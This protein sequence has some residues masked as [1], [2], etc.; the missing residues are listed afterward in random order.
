MGLAR[1]RNVA[2]LPARCDAELDKDLPQVPFDRVRAQ[3]QLRG[4]LLICQAVAGQPRDLRLL[5]SQLVARA[6]RLLAHLLAGRDQLS[7]SPLGKPC[8]P[9]R[10]NMSWDS[11]SCRRASRRRFMRR[12]HSP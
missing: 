9:I 7:T 8:A 12:S 5:G 6:D 4:D 1:A 2:E 10:V 3:E 11:L